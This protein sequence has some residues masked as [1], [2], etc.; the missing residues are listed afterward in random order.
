MENKEGLLRPGQKV[1]VAVPLRSEEE[2]LLLPW[3]AVIHDVHGGTWVY[4]SAGERKYVRRRIQLRHVAGGVAALA[5]GPKA[6][7]KVV[8]EGAAELYGT[9]FGH[10]K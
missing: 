10:A 3:S 4:E 2:S 1:V 6:G 9:E 7:T 5:S 8:I